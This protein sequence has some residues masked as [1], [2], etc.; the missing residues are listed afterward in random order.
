M[1]PSLYIAFTLLLGGNALAQDDTSDRAERLA[2]L[3]N[4]V[5]QLSET[6]ELEQEELRND[7]R[8]LELRKVELEGRIRQ[9]ENR[10]EELERL[11]ERQREVISSDDIAA[12]VLTP[13]IL[14]G[15]DEIEAAIKAGLPY[16][17]DERVEAV[18]ALR[19]QLQEGTTDPRKVV[20]R[21]WQVV[22]DEFRLSRENAVDRQVVT[23]PDGTEQMVDV[24]RLGMVAMY[25]RTEDNKTG[26]VVRKDGGWEWRAVEG[27]GNAQILE[28]FE[29]L[30]KQVR[31]GWF[32]LPMALVE[33]SR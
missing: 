2:E 28:L 24:G 12:E 14:A 20:G 7:L 22:E 3:R 33:V 19:R 11:V 17:T 4:E 25:Y 9:E 16:R 27:E 5:E 26:F 31:V 18:N 32:D 23:W 21:L 15:M 8:S 30:E 29:N 6:L 10:L 13:T 1:S